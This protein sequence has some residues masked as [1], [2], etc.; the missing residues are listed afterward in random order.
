MNPVPD[1]GALRWLTEHVERSVG[2]VIPPDRTFLLHSRLT[3]LLLEASARDILELACLVRASPDGAVARKVREALTT[4]ETLFFRD[5]GVFDRMTDTVLPAARSGRG[6]EPVR[7]WCGAASTGQEPY[8]LAMLLLEH[9]ELGSAWEIV[10]SDVNQAVLERARDGRYAPHE[11][12]RG[13]SPDRRR[14]FFTDTPDGAR[15]VPGLQGLVRFVCHNLLH[16]APPFAESDVTVLRNVLYYFEPNVR[17]AV[18]HKVVANLAP[19]G[20]L[21][22]GATEFLAE[23]DERRL[24]LERHL[25][26]RILYYTRRPYGT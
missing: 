25:K 18:L 26:E 11:L 23:P 19:R 6:A 10:A 20:M 5:P 2:L 17:L 21:V 1:D 12:A 22:L 8:S 16:D 14:R 24:G 4:N 13:L 15:V 9:P 3:P 7:I